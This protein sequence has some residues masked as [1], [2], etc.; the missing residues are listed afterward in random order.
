M[1]YIISE[2]CI[3]GSFRE[4]CFYYYSQ[5]IISALAKKSPISFNHI[6]IAP[7]AKNL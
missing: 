6:K 7:E 1:C 4:N 2:I 5:Q 3:D